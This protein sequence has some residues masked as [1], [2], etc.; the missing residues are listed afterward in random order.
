MFPL[1]LANPDILSCSQESVALYHRLPYI[2]E[3]HLI[4]VSIKHLKNPQLKSRVLLFQIHSP[5][6][7]SGHLLG[8]TTHHRH[9]NL[10]RNL[11]LV[12]ANHTLLVKE[13]PRA[14]FAKKRIPAASSTMH[15]NRSVDKAHVL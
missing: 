4:Q 13:Q 5:R 7:S 2:R 10:D 1:L 15:M 9:I 12:R 14:N 3:R 8:Q 6:Q 11:H